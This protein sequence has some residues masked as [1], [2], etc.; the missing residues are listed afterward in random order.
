[1]SATKGNVRYDDP[2]PTRLRDLLHERH[3][4][5]QVLADFVD[6]KRQTISAYANGSIEPTLSKLIAIAKFFGRSI[7][8]LSGEHDCHTPDR[9]KI[10]ERLGLSEEAIAFLEPEN[11]PNQL[12]AHS[13]GIA[14]VINI[15]LECEVGQEILRR[16]SY[17]FFG[18]FRKPYFGEN[19]ALDGNSVAQALLLNIPSDLKQLR[20]G[21]I[22]K[23]QAGPPTNSTGD[24]TTYIDHEGKE[25]PK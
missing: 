18:D 4:S 23:R 14:G 20:D 5:Q 3:I 24:T 1:M 25:A 2:F 8:Y 17:Y 16:L 12:T 7:D 19:M 6:V 11:V 13:P 9:Q 15:L 22:S 21:I 10:Y